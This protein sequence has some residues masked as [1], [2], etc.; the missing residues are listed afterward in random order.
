VATRGTAEGELL[1]VDGYN[2][3]RA[4]PLLQRLEAV[5]LQ[6]AR[7]AL[8]RA[9]SWYARCRKAHVVVIWDGDGQVEKPAALYGR[10]HGDA[11]AAGGWV[12]VCFSRAP[13]TADDLIKQAIER[14]HGA[15]YLRVITSDRQIRQHARRH[16]VATTAAADFVREL[17]EGPRPVPSPTP[18]PP[19]RELDPDLSL[20]PAEVDAWERLFRERPGADHRTSERG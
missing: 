6:A 17:E 10:G 20:S 15:R 16:R 9:L 19:P 11:P 7:H 14:R 3:L 1:L 2:L 4:A 12:E 5:S 13:E 8:E 18:L